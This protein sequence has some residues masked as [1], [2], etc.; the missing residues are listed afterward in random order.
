METHEQVTAKKTDGLHFFQT[1]KKYLY[2]NT[3]LSIYIKH[4]Q[5]CLKA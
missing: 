4:A 1:H 5:T 2:C 3:S